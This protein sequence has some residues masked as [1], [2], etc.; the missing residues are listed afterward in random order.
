MILTHNLACT[1]VY[2]HLMPI[3]VIAKDLVARGFE[4]TFVT[5]SPYKSIMEEIGCSFVPLEGY[6]DYTEKDF[7]DLPFSVC[8]LSDNFL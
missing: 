5:G 3:R 4:V 1:P 6:S 7:E 2:G 8:G